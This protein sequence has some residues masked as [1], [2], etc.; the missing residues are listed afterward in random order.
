MRLTFVDMLCESAHQFPCRCRVCCTIEQPSKDSTEN[1]T[2][3]RKFYFFQSFLSNRKGSLVTG[4]GV[5]SITQAKVY[6]VDRQATCKFSTIMMQQIIFDLASLVDFS[7]QLRDFHF[8][9]LQC[10]CAREMLSAG[11]GPSV[12]W[13]YI[14]PPEQ[15]VASL[16]FPQLVVIMTQDVSIAFLGF[17]FY[18]CKDISQSS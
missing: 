4:T 17:L 18:R 8:H 16:V 7:L 12:I 1:I 3:R 14:S 10:H 9:P 13:K 15:G 6:Y 11:P 2:G 5:R